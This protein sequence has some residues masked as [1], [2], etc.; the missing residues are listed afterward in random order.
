M[1]SVRHVYRLFSCDGLGWSEDSSDLVAKYYL[2]FGITG[3]F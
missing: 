1:V 2:D 3:K